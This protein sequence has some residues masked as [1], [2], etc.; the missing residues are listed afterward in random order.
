MPVNIDR[1]EREQSPDPRYLIKDF[2]RSHP[3]Y[4]YTLEELVKVLASGKVNLGVEEAQNA[5]TS[6][7]EWG[8]IKTKLANGVKY[9]SH[10]VIGFRP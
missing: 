7:E 3:R 9:Y 2:L 1:I 8:W 5:L 4:A 6:L 10:K